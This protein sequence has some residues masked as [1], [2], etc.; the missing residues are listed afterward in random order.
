VRKL[1]T[2]RA[3]VP[4][5]A[6]AAAAALHPAPVGAAPPAD[7]RLRILNVN[8]FYG[9][10]EIAE[11][12]SWCSH[13]DG[14]PENLARVIDAIRAAAPDIVALEEGEHN[15]RV[16]ADALGFH[17]SE[18]MQIASRYPLIDPP[19]GDGVYVFAEVAPGRV[20]A[21]MNVH[22]P[23]DPYGPYLV[24][25]GATLEEVLALE[26]GLRVPA[27]GRQLAA[28]PGL[29]AQDIPVFLAGDFNSPSHLDWTPAVA[30]V[31]SE[32]PYPIDWPVSRAL[33][34]AGFLD[35]Y[36]EVHPDPVAVPGFTW[37]PGSLEGEADEVHDRIDWVLAAGA[38]IA[39]DSTVLGEVGGADV[40]IEIPDYPTDH[41]GV[42]TTFD[43]TPAVPPVLVAVDSRRAFVGD[44]LP[45][46]FHAPGRSGER[47]AIAPAGGDAAAALVALP[48]GSERPTDGSV[49]F[50]TGGLAPGAYDALLLSARDVVLSRSRFWLYAAGTEPSVATSQAVYE[51]G[52]PI[53]VSWK[54]APGMRW[55]WLG[56]YSPGA[57][58][59]NER[60]TTCNA[61]VCGNGH[62]LLYEY[63]RTAVEGS[64]HFGPDS[65]AGYSTWP[66]QPGNY[67]IRLLL[68][69]G[70]RSLAV[71][72]PFK[73]VNP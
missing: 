59:G 11:S 25:D 5:L 30:A 44:P 64:T 37:T 63:T 58:G 49:V 51:S 72:A 1:H 66:L 4:I 3:L 17:P 73:V 14:C 16:I 48:T 71:S 70:Y 50:A 61:T 46:A 57:V 31:R 55:D 43:V 34:T 65:L 41:R 21:L 68:D 35:S 54:A 67:E 39:V 22:L 36:R 19:G 28:L 23:A 62:Y 47:V 8:I 20:V 38:A 24:R 7:V 53:V 32:V 52:E 42:V 2:L 15:T 26:N 45:V 29:L 10:D 60:A 13:G 33:V 69:D 56:I 6:G 12:G 18:R 9:G 27:I 40:G